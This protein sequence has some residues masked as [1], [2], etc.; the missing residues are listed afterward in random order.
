[1]WRQQCWR[2]ARCRR[3]R[4]SGC[5]R[6]GE[7]A[8][9]HG[10]SA[11]KLLPLPRS[12]LQRKPPPAAKSVTKILS[13]CCMVLV[14]PSAY[15]TNL[16]LI[17]LIVIKKY[18]GVLCSKMDT[19]RGFLAKPACFP[20]LENCTKLSANWCNFACAG[21]FAHSDRRVSKTPRPEGAAR[22]RE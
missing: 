2:R 9:P 1:M 11:W 13:S 7:A 8:H 20:Q 5:R 6:S 3:P 17:L 4:G 12:A 10:R 19:F 21:Q 15:F 22:G 14:S 18:I 16:S